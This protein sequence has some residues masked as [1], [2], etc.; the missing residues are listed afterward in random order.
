MVFNIFNFYHFIFYFQ[1]GYIKPNLL[2][3]N[4]KAFTSNL[5]LRRDFEKSQSY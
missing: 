5:S 1:Y 4:I 3:Q 2:Q